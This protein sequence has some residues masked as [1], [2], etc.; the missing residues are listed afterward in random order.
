MQMTDC[1][2]SMERYSKQLIAELKKQLAELKA[3]NERLKEQ[4]ADK[5]T[6]LHAS[7]VSNDKLCD[8]NHNLIQQLKEKDEEI[9]LNQQIIANLEKQRDKAYDDYGYLKKNATEL[10]CQ[11]VDYEKQIA[12]LKSSEKCLAEN[13]KRLQLELKEQ[14][15][16]LDEVKN[17]YTI[18]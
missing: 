10:G 7:F 17:K 1:H 14:N 15:K 8:K 13:V 9:E 2:F 6:E 5:D 3:E 18:E 4:L 16:L 12:L 11:N